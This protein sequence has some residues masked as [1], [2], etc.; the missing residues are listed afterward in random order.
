MTTG[1]NTTFSGSFAAN[2]TG[3]LIMGGPG[4]LTFGAGMNLSNGTL[5]LFGGTLKLNGYTS[6]FGTLNVASNSILDFGTS[7]SSVL[8]I[9]NSLTVNSGVTLTIQNWTDTVDY[10][11]S[12][13]N[14]GADSLGR[15]VFTGFTG[16]DTK[17]VPYGS[18]YQI[19]PVPEPATYGAALMLLGLSA[20]AWLRRR[21]Q[22]RA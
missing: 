1:N 4:S 20:G 3:T 6:T 19:T 9:L 5:T 2:D 22:N 14:P 21:R 10:F 13:T 12:L 16:A 7:G 8:N 18:T 11:Y 17:W 15:I